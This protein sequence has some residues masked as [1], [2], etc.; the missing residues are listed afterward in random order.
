MKTGRKERHLATKP[1]TEPRGSVRFLRGGF[2]RTSE[3]HTSVGVINPATATE[4]N[5]FARTH[6]GPAERQN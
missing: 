5:E 1:P 2:L 4:K 6:L 3:R